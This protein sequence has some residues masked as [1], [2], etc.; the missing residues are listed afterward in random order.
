VSTL[1][2]AAVYV[3]YREVVEG[4]PETFSI[5]LGIVLLIG[6]YGITDNIISKTTR[7]KINKIKEYE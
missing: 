7:D 1:S 6:M 5:G 4:N 3:A 2:F